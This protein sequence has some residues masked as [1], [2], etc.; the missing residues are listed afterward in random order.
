MLSGDGDGAIRAA[1]DGTL[2][3]KGVFGAECDGREL[4][5]KG[6]AA[7]RDSMH[8]SV[9]AVTTLADRPYSSR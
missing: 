2:L 8:P 4:L 9:T 6:G 1:D 3:T 7:G 5:D